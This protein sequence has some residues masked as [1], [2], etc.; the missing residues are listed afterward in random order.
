[1]TTWAHFFC[2]FSTC[3]TQFFFNASFAES[4]HAFVILYT[5]TTFDTAECLFTNSTYFFGFI[6]AY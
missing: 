6:K 5:I 1:M 2:F 3:S 4:T